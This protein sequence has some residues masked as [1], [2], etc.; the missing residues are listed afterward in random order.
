[1]ATK[2]KK[3]PAKKTPVSLGKRNGSVAKARTIFDGLQEKTR[4]AALVACDKAGINRNT[5]STQWQKY[6]QENGL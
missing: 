2:A 4:K 6:R 1:M 3:T 5:A